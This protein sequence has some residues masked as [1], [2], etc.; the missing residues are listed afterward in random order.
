MLNSNTAI[1]CIAYAVICSIAAWLLN[2]MF[3]LDS[4]VIAAMTYLCAV[5]Y[6]FAYNRETWEFSH[7]F[8]AILVSTIFLVLVIF[9]KFMN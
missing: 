8:T 1:F 5:L 2:W 6:A 7:I 9:V 3:G 4:S